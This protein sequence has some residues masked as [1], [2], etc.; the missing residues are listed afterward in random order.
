MAVSEFALR[1]VNSVRFPFFNSVHITI[2][3][4]KQVE[5]TVVGDIMKQQ[6]FGQIQFKKTLSILFLI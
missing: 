2:D 4:I 3:E 5:T 1:L 6:L